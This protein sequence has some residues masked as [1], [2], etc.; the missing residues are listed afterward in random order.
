MPQT[1]RWCNSI[2]AIGKFLTA[3]SAI[4]SR[5]SGQRAI[6]IIFPQPCGLPD[7]A[8]SPPRSSPSSS[9]FYSLSGWRCGIVSP[10]ACSSLSRPSGSASCHS[11]ASSDFGSSGGQSGHGRPDLPVLTLAVP[12]SPITQ[13]LLRN[14]DEVLTRP[15]VS[16]ARARTSHLRF[17]AACR[18][19]RAACMTV[20]RRA[21]CEIL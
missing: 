2:S 1:G 5:R 20:A 10:S 4:E 17:L 21:V 9:P 16:V 13:I 19:K 11:T 7:L 18:Q 12:I 8:F 6:A 14:I 15:F 3:T